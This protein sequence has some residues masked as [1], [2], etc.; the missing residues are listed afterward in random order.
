VLDASVGEGNDWTT[1]RV[2]LDLWP[3]AAASTLAAVVVLFG[4]TI[5]W[6]DYAAALALMV[7]AGGTRL[8]TWRGVPTNLREALSSFV[9]LIA[10]T[11]LRSAGGGANAGV[12]VV[13]LLPV[14]W[15]S[16]H[17]D[18][19]QL[20]LVVA[21]VAV[22]FL[23]PLLLVG[24]PDYPRSQYRAG[25]LYLAVS[26]IIGFTTQWLVS[27]V[28]YQAS[29][30]Q[31][32]GRMLTQIAQVVRGLP[33]S[34]R[35]RAEACEATRSISAA[36]LVALFEPTADSG[37]LHITA[38]AG[39]ER[40]T[41]AAE[42][43]ADSPVHEVFVSRRSHLSSAQ[44]ILTSTFG[45]DAWVA[46]GRPG[47]AL[48]EPVTRSQQTM[49]VLVVCW[50]QPIPAGDL[51]VD[52]ISLLAHEIGAVIELADRM[53]QLNDMASTDALTGLPNRRAWE[54]SLAGALA[55]TEPVVVA[56]L[57]L[58][59]FK[60]FNDT[61]GHPAGDRL[62]KEAAAAWRGELR[63]GDFLARLG[64]EEFGLLL[65]NCSVE[66]ALRVVERLRARMPYD[67][68]CSAGVAV[69]IPAESAENLMVRADAALYSAKA[70]GRDRVWL[71]P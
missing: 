41:L 55:D 37:A 66:D 19:R 13:A 30:A 34:P 52:M 11:F 6:V 67:Q 69:R 8:A 17:G 51:R 44:D 36:S 26:A 38:F 60:D 58:D 71:V 48:F 61:R 53:T 24:A 3:F 22:F 46:A 7:I 21:G 65:P 31:E 23:A 28:R 16:L 12:S 2:A 5:N 32:R 4:S 10:V 49:G 9:F 70:A 42:L 50:A 56:M 25:V 45:S 43:E 18:R 40:L 1:R 39:P 14:F 54:T 29:E 63:A 33:T 57:D 59:H 15:T 68:T 27:Q 62:L 20:S 64:G 35:A 47:S